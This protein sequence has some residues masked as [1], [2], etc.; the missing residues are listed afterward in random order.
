MSG[1]QVFSK[2]TPR[3]LKAKNSGETPQ[4]RVNISEIFWPKNGP[5]YYRRNACTIFEKIYTITT[6]KADNIYTV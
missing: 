3:T 5:S 4:N 2:N 1:P 6:L